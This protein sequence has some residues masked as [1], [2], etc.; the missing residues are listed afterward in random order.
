MADVRIV[1]DIGRK[2]KRGVE[3]RAAAPSTAAGEKEKGGVEGLATMG[4][5]GSSSSSSK[6]GVGGRAT[7][8]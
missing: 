8:G 3:G 4:G 2:K 7:T 1:Y 5:S 6:K